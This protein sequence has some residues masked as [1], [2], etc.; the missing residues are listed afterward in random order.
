MTLTL[1]KQICYLAF[2]DEMLKA[3]EEKSIANFSK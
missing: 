1:Y 2:K 3:R